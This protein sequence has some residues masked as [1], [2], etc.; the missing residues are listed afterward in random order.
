[1]AGLTQPLK[2]PEPETTVTDAEIT[3]GIETA[4]ARLDAKVADVHGYYNA[5][6]GCWVAETADELADEIV[7]SWGESAK[8]R[9][10]DGAS[11]HRTR[12]MRQT[13][14]DYAVKALRSCDRAE[15]LVS[16]LSGWRADQCERVAE[17]WSDRFNRACEVLRSRYGVSA[18]LHMV[19]Q[20]VGE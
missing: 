16:R 7:E 3:R 8:S 17:R 12:T 2:T 18:D 14:L 1:M 4:A 9:E 13:V 11:R 6:V 19:R 5:A 10:A 20:L 15:D